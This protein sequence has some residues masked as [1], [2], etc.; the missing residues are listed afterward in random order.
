[1]L[2]VGGILI[3][4]VMEE[5]RIEIEFSNTLGH[6]LNAEWCHEL[7]Y[8]KI[9]PY[10]REDR[11]ADGLEQIL[12]A[13][14]ERFQKHRRHVD[15]NKKLRKKRKYVNWA[16]TTALVGGG[17]YASRPYWRHDGNDDGEHEPF[18][19]HEQRAKFQQRKKKQRGNHR[20]KE[21]RR[22]LPQASRG[23]SWID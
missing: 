9:V 23:F 20:R 17:A 4:M 15:K 6:I 8:T 18:P 22:P 14:H 3:L 11:Y 7:L 21:N 10:F 1:M 13:L 12:I 19:P 5:N 2:H 16:G